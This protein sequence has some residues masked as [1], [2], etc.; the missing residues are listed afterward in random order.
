MDGSALT[1]RAQINNW[2]LQLEKIEI[3]L[4]RQLESVRETRRG[5]RHM[6]IALIGSGEI[7][8]GEGEHTETPGDQLQK[9]ID[10]IIDSVGDAAKAAEEAS[11][12]QRK[13]LTGG[14]KIASLVSVGAGK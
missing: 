5:F 9:Q 10:K 14:E 8:A 6:R 1:I 11:G 12:V 13:S 3:N 7:I 2:D 4:V